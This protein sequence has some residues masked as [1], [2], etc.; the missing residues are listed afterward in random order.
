[1]GVYELWGCK[2]RANPH[3]PHVDHSIFAFLCPHCR[4]ADKQ[5]YWLTCWLT[6]TDPAN[7]LLHHS[8][9]WAVYSEVAHRKATQG[10]VRANFKTNL[11]QTARTLECVKVCDKRME[12]WCLHH[13]I[14]TM[15]VSWYVGLHA[16]RSKPP[17]TCEMAFELLCADM[18]RS[19]FYYF[20]LLLMCLGHKN[21]F[22]L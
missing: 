19:V 18:N 17:I 14:K 2:C 15:Q 5:P 7:I 4:L 21:W 10:S 13:F 11:T 8:F 6:H 22:S 3:C 12:A 1:M 16:V 20:V 9:L